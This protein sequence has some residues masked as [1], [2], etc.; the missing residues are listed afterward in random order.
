MV[1][2]VFL[3]VGFLLGGSMFGG[4]IIGAF[5]IAQYWLWFGAIF[6]TVISVVVMGAFMFGGA[7]LGHDTFGKFG[8]VVT[9]GGAGLFGA[10]ISFLILAGTYARL[11]LS[12]YIIEH[13]S[14]EAQSWSDLQSN[15]QVAIMAFGVLLI[16]GVLRSASSSS[17]K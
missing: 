8:A 14:M 7:A 12:Y 17:S 16:I 4:Q 11:W 10:F 5:D 2:V 6:A 13:T 9:M 3:V 1:T 15:T